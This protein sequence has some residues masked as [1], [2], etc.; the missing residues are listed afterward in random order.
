MT[1][2]KSWDEGSLLGLNTVAVLRGIIMR[3][4][5]RKLDI[6]SVHS[7]AR[8]WTCVLLVVVAKKELF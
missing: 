6:V 3:I 2:Y 5:V 1:A 4:P 8:V 7:F